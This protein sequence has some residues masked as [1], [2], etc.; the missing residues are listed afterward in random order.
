MKNIPMTLSIAL[1]TFFPTALMAQTKF[2]ILKNHYLSSTQPAKPHD[3]PSYEQLKE[4]RNCDYQESNSTQTFYTVMRKAT[5]NFADQGPLFPAKSYDTIAFGNA[6]EYS[7]TN[8]QLITLFTI[9]QQDVDTVIVSTQENYNSLHGQKTADGLT[10][11][12]KFGP[13]EG[14]DEIVYLRKSSQTNTVS[15]KILSKDLKTNVTTEYYG[16]CY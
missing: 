11:F 2:E 4:Y 1:M 10:V 3:F 13:G 7:L 15:F 9:S 5:V 14:S 12:K 8:L 16:Y 6:A